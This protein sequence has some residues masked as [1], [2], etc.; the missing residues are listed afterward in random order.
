MPG[1]D[2]RA[3]AFQHPL[4]DGRDG[5]I[6]LGQGDEQA[7]RHLAQHGIIPAQQGFGAQHGAR[8]QA[9]LRLVMHF[10]FIAGDGAAQLLLHG[11]AGADVAA[12]A[13]GEKRVMVAPHFLGAHQRR[14]GVAQHVVEA[15]AIGRAHGDA[16]AGGQRQAFAIDAELP[17]QA[18]QDGLR[19]RQG[20]SQQ[21]I[22][23]QQNLE[24]IAALARHRVAL[25]HA[26]GEETRHYLQRLV[27]HGLA[28]RIVDVLEAVQVQAHQHYL[29]AIAHGLRAR[30]LEALAHQ[31]AIGQ[32]RQGIVVGQEVDQVLLGLAFADIEEDA[33]IVDDGAVG[34]MHGGGAE[35]AGIG[36]AALAPRLHLARPA[37]AAAQALA[38][39]QQHGFARV[40]GVQAHD[41]GA[42]HFLRRVAG[43]ARKGGIGRDDDAGRIGDQD[44]ILRGFED[45]ARQAQQFLVGAADLHF[46]RQGAGHLLQF[47]R[48]FG[49]AALQVGA[50]LRQLQ[51]RPRQAYVGVRAG[52]NFL[53]LERLGDEVDGTQRKA[54]HLVVRI[55]LGRQEDHGHLAQGRN[56]L[57]APAHF[58]TVEARH[59]HVE[60]DQLGR[61]GL[62]RPQGQFAIRRLAHRIPGA[63]QQVTQ[64][65][66]RGR[67]IF[68]DQYFA[69]GVHFRKIAMH[70][71]VLSALDEARR[72]IA[73]LDKTFLCSELRIIIIIFIAI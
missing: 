29:L 73:A 57:Q 11:Q 2:L 28:V 6:F 62:R 19:Q 52:E 46:A 34:A 4:A 41:V 25:A 56:F 36:V 68:N 42:H 49:H 3:D 60:Q 16:D 24:F 13:L 33:D 70:V 66:E 27:A 22:V 71:A 64:Q 61:T 55:V 54:A 50:L 1:A 15:V 12:H 39:G 48:A 47:R 9:H 26:A 7:G 8:A 44:G 20:T 63:A 21:G 43:N 35:Q 23:L 40:F 31:H 53:G 10:E 67:R 45:L 14:V 59:A 5:T 58:K 32:A 30:L 18:G 65:L 37:A 51:L 38:Q 17:A 72:S 69:L